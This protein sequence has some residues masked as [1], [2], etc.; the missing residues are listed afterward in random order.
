MG[1]ERGYLNDRP[2]PGLEIVPN[3]GIGQAGQL[4]DGWRGYSAAEHG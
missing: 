1:Q 4:E 2:G 3:P